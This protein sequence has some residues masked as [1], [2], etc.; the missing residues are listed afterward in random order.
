MDFIES[1]DQKLKREYHSIIEKYMHNLYDIELCKYIK[2][3]IYSIYVWLWSDLIGERKCIK[4]KNMVMSYGFLAKLRLSNEKRFITLENDYSI[5]KNIFNAYIHPVTKCTL[6]N[7]AYANCKLYYD[8]DTI[9][10]YV[11]NLNNDYI[12]H[13]NFVNQ[14]MFQLQNI[15]DE[16]IY[17]MTKRRSDLL[18]M[19]TKLLVDI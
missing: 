16:K 11:S 17:K 9:K 14:S 5:V 3:N 4:I 13:E 12:L 2:T 8:D 18:V 7:I 15:L 6:Y 1:I 19:I 10:K